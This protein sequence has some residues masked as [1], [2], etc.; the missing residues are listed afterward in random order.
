[1]TREK[2]YLNIVTDEVLTESQNVRS[3]H[4]LGR[5]QILAEARYREL[6]K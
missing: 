6:T 5:W 2:Q 4:S 3:D 1:M